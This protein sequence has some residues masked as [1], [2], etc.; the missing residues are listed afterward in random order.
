MASESHLPIIDPE[1]SPV[2]AIP[3]PES[4]AAEENRRLRVRILEMWDAWSNGKEPPSTIP[5]FPKLLPRTGRNGSEDK[6]PR[7]KPEKHAR[8]EWPKE[9]LSFRE[10]AIKRREQAARVKPPMDE[11]EMVEVFLQAQEADYFENMM[12]AMDKHFAEAIKIREMVENDLKTGGI[13][14]QSALR[15]TSQAIQNG[16]GGLANRKKREERAMLASGSRGPRRSY[17]HSYMTPR[18]P[19][20]YYPHQDA[21]YAVALPHYAMM[22]AQP[23]TRPQQH[24]NQARDPSPRNNHPHIAP[25]N[26]R[27]PPNNYQHNLRPR[28]PPRRN[29]FIHVGESYSSL[30]SKLIQMGLLQPVPP[31]RQN[32]ESSSY[33]PSTRCAYHSGAKGHD[34][35]DCWTLKRAV[36]NLIEQKRVVVRDEEVPNV[37]NNPLPA[38]NDG[39]TIGM[40]WDD[41][42]F[43]PALKA[44]IAIAYSEARP[45]AAVKQTKIEKKVIPIPQAVGKVVETKTR[46]APIKNAILYVPKALRKEQLILNT[47][48]RFE[49]RKAMLNV[50]KLYVPKGS[51]VARGPNPTAVPWNYNRTVV[52]YKGKEVMGEVNEMN[53]SG[54]YHNPEELKKSKLNKDKRLPPK[55]PV[56]LLSL[57][58]SSNEHQKVLLKTLNEA[59]VPV[60]TSNEQLERMAERFFEVNRIS[61]SHDDL[62]PEGA[63]DNKALHLIVK[64]EGYYVKRVVLDGGSRVDI[65]PLSTLQ[66]MEIGT[67]RIRPNNVC[68]RAFN[69]VKRDTIGEIDLI[70]IIGPVDFEVTI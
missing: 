36:E 63:A 13:L 2:S 37:S 6:K 26:P 10:Y 33:R 47:P 68:V 32:P 42:E 50:P 46:E 69:G 34:T 52:T 70:L 16:S 57:L 61:F 7:T 25:Y 49:Q 41:K 4:A 53:Q 20:H 45:K 9:R 60:E 11:T 64:Y 38:Q 22:N 27:P 55:N 40:I 14:S 3:A 21:A 66:R 12:S 23:Y 1:D 15:S 48:K 39:P 59:Y 29:N 30:F 51:Y 31:N 17:D 56:S 67:E 44:I 54:K 62:P 24:Y 28:E 58:L 65:C 19:Q 8:A 43:K 18:T 35:E 5:G